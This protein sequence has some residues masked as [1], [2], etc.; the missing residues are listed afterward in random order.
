MQFLDASEDHIPIRAAEVCG[1]VEAGYG[2]GVGTVKH[3]VLSIAS[4]Y[5]GSQILEGTYVSK[6][7]C[8]WMEVACT[9][10]TTMRTYSMDLDIM[11]F[12]LFF[13]SE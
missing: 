4:G 1:S 2:I 10:W 9:E 13:D 12:V 11:L 5:L 7:S 3:D 8:W 6:V